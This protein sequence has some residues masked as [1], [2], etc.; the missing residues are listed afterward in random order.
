MQTYCPIHT[1]RARNQARVQKGLT[2]LQDKQQAAGSGSDSD[3]ARDSDVDMAT[4]TPAGK[5]RGTSKSASAG[6]KR[7]KAE[8]MAGVSSAPAKARG[9]GKGK[10]KGKGKSKAKVSTPTGGA[11]RTPAS[12][13]PTLTGADETPLPTP[14]DRAAVGVDPRPSKRQRLRLTPTQ[15]GPLSKPSVGPVSSPSPSPAADAADV[16]VGSTLE[17]FGDIDMNWRRGVV[18]KVLAGMG[19][20]QP[21]LVVLAYADEAGG[22]ERINLACVCSLCVC[23]CVCV[24]SML[25]LLTV[26]CV[27]SE[28]P[29]RVVQASAPSPNR[30]LTEVRT[31]SWCPLCDWIAIG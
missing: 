25:P 17:V 22:K 10:G 14:V 1:S 7:K 29:F 15:G 19:K 2:A 31:L 3:D 5:R 21:P 24:C 26:S 12:A 6:R 11:Y 20:G 4:P 9:R 28:Q 23:V 18:H 30:S 27:Y 8:A 16:S 13:R